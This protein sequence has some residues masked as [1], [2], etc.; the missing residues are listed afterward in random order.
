MPRLSVVIPTYNRADLIYETIDSILAQTYRDYE[1]IVV[2]DGSTDLT[3]EVVD[4]YRDKGVRLIRQQNSGP[5]AA[6]NN[7]IQSAGGELVA[8]VDDDDLWAPNKLERQVALFDQDPGLTWAYS[9]AYAFDSDTRREMYTWSQQVQL[10]EGWIATQLI[11]QDFIPSPTPVVRRNVFDV[12]GYFS[13]KKKPEAEDWE[14]WLRIASRY[15]VGL[16]RETLAGY[17]QHARRLTIHRDPLFN[18]AYKLEAIEQV[19]AFAPEVYSS[20]KQRAV[21][22]RCLHTGKILAVQGNF[23]GARSMFFQAI[24]LAPGNIYP[25]VYWMG[26]LFGRPGAK[27]GLSLRRWLKK[28]D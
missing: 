6:R 10:Y 26:S 13:E 1:V 5:G 3:P 14:M 2:D 20:L 22:E 17:R 27:L 28:L 16:V 4:R 19:V 24:R 21:A 18:H 7:G 15:P 23:A 8:F 12:V 25:Y 9:D 11:L